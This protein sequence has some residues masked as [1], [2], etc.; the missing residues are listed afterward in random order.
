MPEGTYGRRVLLAVTGMSPQIVTETMWALMSEQNFVPTEVRVVTTERGRNLLVRNLITE[1]E[2]RF[3][4]FCEEYGLTGQIR[5]GEEDIVVIRDAKGHPLEDI[6][7][8]EENRLAADMIVR[9]VEAVCRDPQAQ[10]HVSIAGGRKSMGFFAGYAMSLFGRAQD[11]VSHVLVSEAFESNRDFYYPPKTPQ[12]IFAPDGTELNTADARVM[13]AEI[14]VVRLRAGLPE[15]LLEGGCTFS[16][17]VREAQARI[18]PIR[19]L[20]IDLRERKVFCADTEVRLTPIAFVV[21]AWMVRRSLDGQPAVRP[22][23]AEAAEVLRLYE[24][25]FPENQADRERAAAAMKRADDV[26][27]YLQEKRSRIHD[28]LRRALGSVGAKPYLI[29]AQGK[30]PKT[31]YGLTLER[32]DLEWLD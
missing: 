15:A 27:P 32:E 12:T 2:A 19:S 10:L 31:T 26:L 1:P 20:R 28:A 24:R 25:I 30:R 21:L 17:A 23:L 14:P 29:E 5:F 18:R 22:G 11:S 7:T 6:R 16:D 3:R 9:E 13:L 8:P 4:A